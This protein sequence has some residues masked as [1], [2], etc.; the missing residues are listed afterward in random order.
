ME[1]IFD[2]PQSVSLS[3]SDGSDQLSV[4]SLGQFNLLY[5]LSVNGGRGDDFI[6]NFYGGAQN[7]LMV[8]SSLGGPGDDF[9]FEEFL[10]F[11]VNGTYVGGA[12]GGAG[13]DLLDV[14]LGAY[15]EFDPSLP[16]I[17]AGFDVH[18]GG[19]AIYSATGGDDHDAVLLDYVGRIDGQLAIHADGGRSSDDIF[20]NVDINVESSGQLFAAFRGGDG[21]D[22]LDIRVR[23]IETELVEIE[24]GFFLEGLVGFS[25][26]PA[27]LSDR[28]II[29][30]G[31]KG[32]DT[33]VHSNWVT[34]LSIE[35]DQPL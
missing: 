9:I 27:P 10:D 2:S 35:D 6:V 22:N 3:G 32:F 31:G 16:L 1:G 29:A 23:F 25:E 30:D 4:Q 24:P 33:C 20:A 19:R 15:I 14:G 12:D 13:S 8:T 5:G 26:T 11:R 34:L 21:N 17:V 7:G 28:L 18:Q